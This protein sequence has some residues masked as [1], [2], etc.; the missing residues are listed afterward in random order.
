M[1][2][3]ATL[4]L[5][6]CQQDRT[7]QR[8]EKAE[9]YLAKKRCEE[10]EALIDSD[11]KTAIEKFDEVINNSRI[12]W[13][14]CRL[15]IEERPSEYTPWYAFLPYQYRGRAKINLAR[16]SDPEVAVKLL[17]GAAA[18]LQRSQKE[19]VVEGSLKEGVK[20]SEDFLKAAK[21]DLDAAEAKIKAAAA[22]SKSSDPSL[23]E[24]A[25]VKFRPSFQRLL[26]DSRFKSARDSV[27]TAGKDLTEAEKKRFREDADVA[28]RTFLDEQALKFRRRLTSEVR[29]LSDLQSL[30]SRELEAIFAVPKPEELFVSHPAIEWARSSLPAFEG[31]RSRKSAAATLLP[32]TALAVALEPDGENQWFGTAEVVAFQ[33]IRDAVQAC[34]SRARDALQ[35]VRDAEKAQA[36]ALVK[37]WTDFETKLEAN[38]REAHPVVGSHGKEISLL[39]GGFPV[40]LAEV[41]RADLDACFAAPSP[42]AAFAQLEQSLKSLESGKTLTRESRRK[43]YHFLFTA[44]ALRALCEGKTEEDAADR[45]SVYGEKLSAAGGA[46]ETKKYGPRMEAVF[47]KLR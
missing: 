30:S 41:D 10:G 23:P 16:K 37:L 17:A 4:L 3:A 2:T 9:Y 27:D 42:E 25:I 18:D 46:I 45:A 44:A 31:V 20:S 34:V 35:P 32:A 8:T 33:G 29:S 11:P 7:V 1:M 36:A 12:R 24:P 6:L 13:I 39:P 21:A 28:C 43:L 47:A 19:G 5:L 15:R 14:E 38:F 26:D 22:S 40:D